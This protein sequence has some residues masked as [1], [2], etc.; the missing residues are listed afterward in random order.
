MVQLQIN[1]TRLLRLLG[2]GCS[3]CLAVSS[4]T[5]RAA[6]PV[7]APASEPA[8]ES[9]AESAA[10]PVVESAEV[11][12]EPVAST[13]EA[14]TPAAS[15]VA[16]VAPAPAPAPKT[17]ETFEGVAETGVRVHL[18]V[19]GGKPLTLYGVESAF[20][21]VASGPGGSAVVQGIH[22]KRVCLAPC[23]KRVSSG[24]GAYFVGGDGYTP[25]K[26]ISLPDHGEVQLNARAGHKALRIGGYVAMALGL[27]GIAAGAINTAAGFRGKSGNYAMIGV[28]SALFVAGVPMFIFG[29]SRV[30]LAAR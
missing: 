2:L 23:D 8:A 14:P 20:A 4:T 3:V 26:Q 24:M 18:E 12:A 15:P 22:Y 13:A 19:R 25:S 5:A 16:D 1:H 21:G 6:E 9:L 27:L 10:E 29:K 7:A 28:G 17:A 11:A 30:K